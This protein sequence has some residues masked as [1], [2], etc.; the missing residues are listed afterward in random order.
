MTFFGDQICH[1]D[2]L[3]TTGETCRS[4]PRMAHFDAALLQELLDL[5]RQL[6]ELAANC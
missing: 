4:A 6:H 2:L 5:F 3:A 1:F